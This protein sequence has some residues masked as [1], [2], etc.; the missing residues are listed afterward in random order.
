[1][2]EVNKLRIRN[3]TILTGSALT[4]LA[5]VAVSPSLPEMSQAFQQVP[6]AD[7]WVRLA[8][9][10]PALVIGIGS[11][12]AGFLLDR[13]GRRPVLVISI[14]FYG[15][16][17]T[18]GFLLDSISGLIISR[19]IF[20]LAVAGV[21]SSFTTLIGDY[22]SGGRLNQFMGY[23]A[24]FMNFAAVLFLVV[25]GYLADI[26]WQYPFLIYLLAFLVLP[27]VLFTIDEPQ[28]R[29]EVA[30]DV[31]P[32]VEIGMPIKTAIM[33]YATAF[34]GMVLLFIVPV[35]MPFYLTEVGGLSNSQVG[36]MLAVQALAGAIV[37]LRY[38]LLKARFSYKIIS[39]LAFLS[40]GIGY[41]I[42]ASSPGYASAFVGLLISGV[43]LGMFLPNINVWLVT[44]A[45]APVRGR[46]VGGLTAAIFLGQ[47]MAPVLSEPI[48]QQFD[49]TGTFATAATASMLMAVAFVAA[50]IRRSTSSATIGQI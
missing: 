25:G 2:L 49:L 29:S 32:A 9:T 4:V 44:V 10:I 48:V 12:F 14:I 26:G 7:F 33:V 41:L 46:A 17:G 22:F 18:A 20:G 42:I 39:S 37:A 19:A 43:A 11:P 47:F 30:E 8:I 6:N 31:G 1:M 15:V 28:I 21:M 36:L 45:P 50:A 23:Q 34:S 5:V 40:L 38:G 35:H 24:A 27:G 13:W 3:L 16:M